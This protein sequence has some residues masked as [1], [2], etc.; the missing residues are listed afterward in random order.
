MHNK[1]NIAVCASNT[2]VLHISDI[3][4]RVGLTEP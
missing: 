2:V 3:L 1:R 4:S